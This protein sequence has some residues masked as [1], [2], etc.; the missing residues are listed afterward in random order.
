MAIQRHIARIG[1]TLSILIGLNA[2]LIERAHSEDEL[3]GTINQTNRTQIWMPMIGNAGAVSRNPDPPAPQQPTPPNFAG[4]S[5][6]TISDGDYLGTTYVDFRLPNPNPAIFDALQTITLPLDQPQPAA[7]LRISNAVTGAPESLAITPDGSTA[8]V[9]E[10]DKAAPVGATRAD[11]LPPGDT[12]F[13]IDMRDSRSPQISVTVTLPITRPSYLELNPAGDVLAIVK[14]NTGTFAFVPFNNGRFGEA[15]TAEITSLIEPDAQFP[16]GGIRVNGFDWHPSGRYAAITL[17]LRNQVLLVEVARD[18]R[19]RVRLSPWGAP[20]PADRDPAF[21]GEFTPDGRFFITNNIRDVRGPDGEP[22]PSAI[23]L[24]SFRG[25][26]SVIRLAAVDTPTNQA[27]HEALPPVEVDT[28]PEGL[29]ISPVIAPF[30]R[31]IATVNLRGTPIPP[32]SG[33][34]GFTRESSI[35]LS[36]MNP[37]TGQLTRLGEYSFEG[38]LPEG[39]AWDA[40]GNTLVVG[41]FNELD[42]SRPSTLEFWDVVPPSEQTP[43]PRLQKSAYEI[44]MMRGLHYIQVVP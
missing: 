12:L 33:L 20:V 44:E 5:I 37:E 1:L 19:G 32:E 34:P 39:I 10:V 8:F 26:L 7:T 38:V 22:I 3:P 23:L 24:N 15:Q 43:F 31:L 4:R 14:Q 28:F 42:Q 17:G 6:V 18:E 29:A 35:S 36:T 11:Q 27:R 16:L 30:G 9:I 25:S 40:E 21:G 13:A 41:V 2:V